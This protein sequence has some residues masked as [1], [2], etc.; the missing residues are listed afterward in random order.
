MASSAIAC[1]RTISVVTSIRFCG[2][3]EKFKGSAT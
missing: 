1:C 3:G 2:E